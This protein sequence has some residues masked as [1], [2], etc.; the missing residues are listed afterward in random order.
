[1]FFPGFP[2]GGFGQGQPPAEDGEDDDRIIKYLCRRLVRIRT[3][4]L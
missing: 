3:N 1:M 4:I 2:F